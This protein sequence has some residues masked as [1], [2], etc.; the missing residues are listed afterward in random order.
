MSVEYELKYIIYAFRAG[1]ES[2]S[3]KLLQRIA[4]ET[5]DA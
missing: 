2:E 1:Q 4:E 3:E 5:F